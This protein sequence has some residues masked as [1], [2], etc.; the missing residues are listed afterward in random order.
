MNS[1]ILYKLNNLIKNDDNIKKKK[2]QDW[3]T[4]QIARVKNLTLKN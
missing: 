1:I 3:C 2:K 4:K